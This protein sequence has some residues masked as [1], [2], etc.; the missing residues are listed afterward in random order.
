VREDF[1]MSR[2]VV[3]VC[4]HGAA[5]S[6]VAAEHFKRL[7]AARGLPVEVSARGTEP[8]AELTPA[9]ATGLRADGIDVGDARPRRVTRD[10]LAGAWRIV[11]FGCDLA[12]LAP[13]GARIE[14]WA[15]VPAVSEGYAAARD[16]IAARLATLVADLAR[17][18]PETDA[19]R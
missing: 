5:K 3:F 13:A 10:D 18:D 19:R 9:A 8:D 4:L 6:V 12:S 17:A 7:A 2:K 15:D 14:R 16:A 11:E 1:E